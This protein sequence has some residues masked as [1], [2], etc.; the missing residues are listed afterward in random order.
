MTDFYHPKMLLAL[1]WFWRD[2][3]HPAMSRTVRNRS[4]SFPE[5]ALT[6]RYPTSSSHRPKTC[7]TSSLH[8]LEP[9]RTRSL[10][11]LEHPKSGQL[12]VFAQP[13][14][15]SSKSGGTSPI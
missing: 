10:Y 1:S 11:N 7:T 8:N 6:V 15:A 2:E 9:A 13:R 12:T 14:P 3:C 5:C 4:C